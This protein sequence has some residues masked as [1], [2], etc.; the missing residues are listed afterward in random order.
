MQG[1]AHARRSGLNAK[2]AISLGDYFELQSYVFK[3][4]WMTVVNVT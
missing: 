1:F 4:I 3:D 2:M